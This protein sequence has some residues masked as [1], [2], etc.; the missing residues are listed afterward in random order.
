MS[1]DNGWIIREVAKDEFVLHPYFASAD[2]YPE[3]KPSDERFMSLE[4]AVRKYTELE[5]ESYPSEYGLTVKLL[6]TINE[7]RARLISEGMGLNFSEARMEMALSALTHPDL[8][9]LTKQYIN[10][11]QS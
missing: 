11:L 10:L 2:D 7:I 9:E 8:I 1:S 4:A 3:I 6:P 5:D